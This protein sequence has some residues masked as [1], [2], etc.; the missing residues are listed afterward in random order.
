MNLLEKLFSE[1]M[2]LE[3]NK[4]VFSNST[5]NIGVFL[6]ELREVSD[7]YAI[8]DFQHSARLFEQN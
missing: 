8:S 5:T 6:K 4:E 3:L 7:D 1:E 2:W